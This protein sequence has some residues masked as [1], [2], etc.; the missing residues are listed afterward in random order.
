MQYIGPINNIGVSS[1]H[2]CAC[3][4]HQHLGFGASTFVLRIPLFSI[5]RSN[6]ELSSLVYIKARGEP[7]PLVKNTTNLL[8]IIVARPTSPPRLTQATLCHPQAPSS[9][10]SHHSSLRFTGTLR[11]TLRYT[12]DS[13]VTLFFTHTHS[14][15]AVCCYGN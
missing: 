13:F 9:T 11:I 6:R 10:P 5:V 3:H 12:Y 15:R 2:V 8:P 7:S 14:L 4:V 1:G